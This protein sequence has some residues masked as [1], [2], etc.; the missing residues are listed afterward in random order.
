MEVVLGAIGLVVEPALLLSEVFAD[1]RKW[2]GHEGSAPFMQKAFYGFCTSRYGDR[3]LPA[4]DGSQQGVLPFIFYEDLE[5]FLGEGTAA[6]A[7]FSCVTLDTS[8]VSQVEFEAAR[9]N[10]PVQRP[11]PAICRVA[12]SHGVDV[13]QGASD[14]LSRVV[15]DLPQL[16]HVVFRPEGQCDFVEVEIVVEVSLLDEALIPRR[17]KVTYTLASAVCHEGSNYQAVVVGADGVHWH[18]DCNEGGLLVQREF[19]A[20]LRTESGYYFECLIYRL[21]LETPLPDETPRKPITTER[22]RTVEPQSL[23]SNLGILSNGKRKHG[24]DPSDLPHPTRVP[25]YTLREGVM[26][27][28]QRVTNLQFLRACTG[29]AGYRYVVSPP[30]SPD[31]GGLHEQAHY[32]ASQVLYYSDQTSHGVHQPGPPNKPSMYYFKFDGDDTGGRNT[33]PVTAA[34]NI[35]ECRTAHDAILK[36]AMRG[37]LQEYLENGEAYICHTGFLLENIQTKRPRDTKQR[38]PEGFTRWRRYK[39]R[40]LSKDRFQTDAERLYQDSSGAADYTWASADLLKQSNG[41]V[42]A[43]HVDSWDP[44]DEAAVV[45]IITL[46][47]NGGTSLLTGH[48]LA[49]SNIHTCLT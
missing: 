29:T 10:V 35:A 22:C 37:V 9:Q 23:V 14:F 7:A 17:T 28:S 12:T 45:V 19:A 36:H 40:T 27:P 32:L 15:G 16:L 1:R 26:T 30:E 6:L 43:C 47:A 3:A 25:C 24:V 31:A 42:G 39:D 33:A 48:T 20:E 49:Y 34:A 8:P 13:H 18:Y 21:L 41:A 38:D 2:V 44:V 4:P 46:T 11:L 5:L